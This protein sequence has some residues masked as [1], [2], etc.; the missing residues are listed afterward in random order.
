MYV[1]K[2]PG[3]LPLLTLSGASASGDTFTNPA[4]ATGLPLDMSDFVSGV[5]VLNVTAISGG[6]AGITVSI[7]TYDPIAGAWVKVASFAQQSAIGVA[8][9]QL[10]PGLMPNNIAVSYAIAGTTPSVSCDVFISAKRR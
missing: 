2:T 10:P 4:V 3:D 1:P 5:A 9:L 7:C 8:T 6:S